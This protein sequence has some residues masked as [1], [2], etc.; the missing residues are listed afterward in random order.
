MRS[1][2]YIKVDTDKV[3]SYFAK[4][5]H[6]IDYLARRHPDLVSYDELDKVSK[7]LSKI[8]SMNVNLRESDKMIVDLLNKK[9]DL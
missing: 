6:Y 8:T 7:E 9:I 2:G 1:I 5:K 4:N 3:M